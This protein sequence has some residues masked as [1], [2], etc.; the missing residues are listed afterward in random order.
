MAKQTAKRTSPSTNRTHH[1]TLTYHKPLSAL[2][3]DEVLQWIQGIRARLQQKMQRERA[4]LNRRA[5]RGV[6]TPTDEAYEADQALE[7]E[8]LGLLDVIEQDIE[9]EVSYG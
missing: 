1:G 2:S 8:L 9:R 3:P 7:A 5:G 6:R 4:Y